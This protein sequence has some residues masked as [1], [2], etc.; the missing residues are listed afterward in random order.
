M[1]LL[2]KSTDLSHLYNL[3]EL[4]EANGIPATVKGEN[5]ARMVTP[6]AMTEPSLWVYIEEQH[7][8]ADKLILD[9]S[10][11]VIHKVDVANFYNATSE[12]TK[13]PKKLNEALLNLG[14]AFGAILFVVFLLLKW[15][16]A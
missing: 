1:K 16:G 3:K 6:F 13:D 15:L 9:P 14:V 12:I 5:A 2:T 11:E 7:S 10:Y 8:D 4:L